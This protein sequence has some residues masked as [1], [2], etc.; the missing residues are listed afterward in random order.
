MDKKSWSERVNERLQESPGEI[1]QRGKWRFWFP[2][3]IGL[4]FLNG[5]LTAW[6]FGAGVQTYIG[7][8]VAT[9]GALLCWLSVG[10]L[11]YSD[12]DDPTLAR[13]VSLLDSITLCFVI[14]HF[15]FLLWANGHLITVR[16]AEEKYDAAALVYNEKQEKIQ[17]DNTKISADAVK[18]A[19]ANV[20]AARLENDTAYWTAKA[21]LR[22]RGA[23]NQ[24]SGQGEQFPALQTAPIELEKP[25]APDESSAA[26][27]SRWDAWIRAA[28]FGELILAAIT[29]IYIRN[30]S[31]KFNAQ[32]A[33]ERVLP[34]ATMSLRGASVKPAL[35][36]NSAQKAT[37]VA[38]D[39]RQEALYALRD[40]LRVISAGLYGRFFKADLIDGGVSIRLC[41][42]VLGADKTIAK[43]RQSDKLLDAVDRPDFRE[44]LVRELIDCG[45]PIGRG[46]R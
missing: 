31:A 21:G 42:K 39:P 17:A 45:F 27:L 15:C 37:P 30:R 2:L 23:R 11:H 4:T 40:H 44:R 43:T 14:A 22:V 1:F 20:K 10:N 46:E 19:E 34:V 3:V 16:G 38:T 25:K 33:P 12:S 18:I 28:N 6:I 41:K 8:I 9:V 13:G 36:A 29:L 35:K 32:S 24:G 7:L 5:L 26:F